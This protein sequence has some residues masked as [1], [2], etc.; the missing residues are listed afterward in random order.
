MFGVGCVVLVGSAHLLIMALSAVSGVSE[1]RR[2][3][4]QAMRA[5]PVTMFGLS[6]DM[7]ELFT[8]ANAAMGLLAIGIGVLSLVAVRQAPHLLTGSRA[9]IWVNLGTTSVLLVVSILAFPP[10]P[11]VALAAATVAFGLA[12]AAPGE[13]PESPPVDAATQTSSAR[14]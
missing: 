11:I 13:A 2:Q 3:A 10:P 14:A 5:A 8:G 6:R 9:V 1:E 12:L 4:R 7:Y